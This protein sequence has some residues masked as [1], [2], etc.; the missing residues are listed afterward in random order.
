MRTFCGFCV[1]VGLL[2]LPLGCSSESAPEAGGQA[3]PPAEVKPAGSETKPAG[4]ETK[5]AGSETKPAG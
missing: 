3:A 2:S 5:P 1:V 4:S